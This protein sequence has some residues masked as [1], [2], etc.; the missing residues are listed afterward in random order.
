MI[1][2]LILAAVLLGVMSLLLAPV[3]LQVDFQKEFSAQVRYLFLR[4][5]LVSAGKEGEAPSMQGPPAEEEPPPSGS[6]LGRKLR[7]MLRRQ[8][9]RG[10][11]RSLQELALAAEHTAKSLLRKIR[12]KRFDLYICLGGEEDAAAAAILYGQVCGAAYSACGILWELFP[13]RRRSVS[14]DLDYRSRD[15]RVEFFAEATIP[16]LFLLR[17]GLI[18]LYKALP[19]F[20]KLQI[21][22][23]QAERISQTRKQGDTK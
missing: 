2:L 3:R 19:F 6:G 14:V 9:L 11:L 10:F 20:K 4:F 21:S 8:G 1:P 22:E 15:H 7:A 5:P 12:L 13:C 18:L 17:E 16:L 23:N